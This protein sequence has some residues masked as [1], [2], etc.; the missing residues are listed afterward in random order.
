[1]SATQAQAGQHEGAEAR[2]R[3]ERRRN[4]RRVGDHLTALSAEVF[5]F[6]RHGIVVTDGE[7]RI[8][9]SNEEA[10]RIV[11]G[12]L[13]DAR[14]NERTCCAL[15]GC[16]RADIEAHASDEPCFT[17]AALA[18]GRQLPEARAPLA[19]PNGTAEVW[20]T[21]APMQDDDGVLLHLRPV[22]R[23]GEAVRPGAARLRI[24][25]LGRLQIEGPSGTLSGPWLSQRP[26]QL[27]K[28]LLAERHRILHA[29]EI[30]E[31]LWPRAERRA[32][33]N[34]RY[35]V[36]LLRSKLEPDRGRGEPSRFVVFAR[37]GYKLDR[38][39]ADID[40]DMFERR[41]ASARAIADPVAATAELESALDLYRDDFLA[42]E[43]FAEWAFAERDRLHEC[44]ADALR[45]L[46]RLAWRNGDLAAAG[47]AVAR[48]ADLDP[49]DLDVQRR[50]LAVCLERGRRSEAQRRYRTLA[51]RMLRDFGEEL[52]FNLEDLALGSAAKLGGFER[53]ADLNG[54]A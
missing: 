15:L 27:L 45:L 18:A 9:A 21:A 12:P 53:A 40:A 19:A 47:R 31:A 7:G 28:L 32:I 8:V 11:G 6:C 1:M 34:V 2:W 50:L 35:Y 16:E 41:V 33:A 25:T 3:E 49:Y 20:V 22:E 39:H 38:R 44:A 48:L 43:P 37:G 54:D 36:H 42:D 29:E 24:T 10:D 23:R 13:E 46:E 5:D 52:D 14:G 17:R 26:G 51:K 30:A 4:Y